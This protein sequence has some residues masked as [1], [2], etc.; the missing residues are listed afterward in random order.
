MTL[1]DFSGK[2]LRINGTEL[3]RQKMAKLGATGVG[4]PL[5]EVMPALDQG[6]ID[7]TISGISVFVALKMND[8]I[9]VITVTNDTSSDRHRGGVEAVARY[10]A[11]GPAKD[12]H[13][14]RRDRAG[15]GAGLGDRLHQA[16]GAELDQRS[17]AT[18]TRFPPTTSPR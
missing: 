8:L 6:T 3:E 17:A 13:R 16:I 18:C 11:A 10:A 2:K 12:R 4:M 9:K 7:G 15:E 5:S 14:C 1:A